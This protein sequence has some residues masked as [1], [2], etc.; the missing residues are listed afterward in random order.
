MA[1]A[2]SDWNAIALKAA[3]P[4]RAHPTDVLRAVAGAHTAMLEAMNFIEQR[5]VPRFVV[6]PVAPISASSEAA[7]AAAAHHVL[8]RLYPDQSAALDAALDRSLAQI[9][10]GS[11]KASGMTTGKALGG[12]IYAVWAW[13][14]AAPA[15]PAGPT[16][17]A[18]DPLLWNLIA[19]KLIEGRGL[20]P[21]EAARVH[22]LVSFAVSEVYSA[23]ARNG[24][25]ARAD[26]TCVPCA[27]GVATLSI[28]E[29]ALA[30]SRIPPAAMGSLRKLDEGTILR[31]LIIYN[32][33]SA[34]HAERRLGQ[35]SG[36]R[37]L[38]HYRPAQPDQPL[39]ACLSCGARTQQS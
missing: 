13:D 15:S 22:A 12:N 27:A 39:T 32:E 30:P 31:A 24:R 36:M 29:S 3:E 34:G 19:A 6:R 20:A 8:A 25:A 23:S 2:V 1:D 33:R 5:Y 16:D 11:D 14:R 4:S 9:P 26:P 17:S 10:D 18:F 38:A 28:L 7:A 37:A 35:R 21:I